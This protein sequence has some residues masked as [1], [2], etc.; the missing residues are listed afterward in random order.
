MAVQVTAAVPGRT[1][2]TGSTGDAE[3]ADFALML[4]ADARL[5]AGGHTQSAGLEA[6]LTGG[7]PVRDIPRYIDFRLRTTATVESGV[8]VMALAE[9][10]SGGDPDATGRRLSDV[11]QQW[12]ARTP[13]H[14]QRRAS[15]AVGR[16]YLRLLRT[17][18]PGHQMTAVLDEL[19]APCRP[20]VVGALAHLLGLG[21]AQLTR[22]ICYDEVQTIGSAALKLTPL[23]PLTTIG[24]AL[25]ARPAVE[26]VVRHISQIRSPTEIPARAA[27]LMEMWVHD[28]ARQNRRLFSA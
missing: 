20:V 10:R 8:A 25:Q 22:L 15:C 3:D 7:M 18:F 12:A 17:L 27:P 19:A 21:G 26:E 24:W 11:Q 9:L 14:V 16:G 1:G 5:P 2:R 6:A 4:L 28:H 23:D 13:S